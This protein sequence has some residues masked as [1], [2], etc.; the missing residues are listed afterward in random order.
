MIVYGL[1]LKGESACSWQHKSYSKKLFY[2]KEKALEY[3]DQFVEKCCD[4][5][6]LD[7]LI[8]GTEEVFVVEYELEDK[9]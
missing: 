4:P 8:K 5:K 2:T 7:Y 6:I 9:I 3:R 1:F